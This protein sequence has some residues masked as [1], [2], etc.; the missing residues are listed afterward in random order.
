MI[1]EYEGHLRKELQKESLSKPIDPSVLSSEPDRRA[2][3]CPVFLDVCL[4]QAR[5]V[6]CP[7]HKL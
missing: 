3:D 5:V 1:G 7:S 4:L 2:A 6:F